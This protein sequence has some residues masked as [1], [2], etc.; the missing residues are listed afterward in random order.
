M[1]AAASRR[2]AP[3]PPLRRVRAPAEALVRTA[4]ERH[5]PRHR[6]PRLRGPGR[7][8]SE[9]ERM[10][11]PDA[12]G[13]L[14]LPGQIRLLRRRES[15]RTGRATCR[16]DG[17]RAPSASGSLRRR[18]PRCLAL[19]PRR[20]AGA[21]RALAANMETALNALWDSRRRPGRPHRGRRGRRGRAPGRAPGGAAAGSG[22]HDGRCRSVARRRSPQ[23]LGAPVRT[24]PDAPGDA[25]VVFH[26]SATRGRPCLRP[27][28]RRPRGARSSR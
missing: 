21:A 20:R 19:V 22:G 14:P 11:A 9:W 12:G 28:L 17:V 23:P 16:P 8:R 6:A 10:R 18:R 5:Q 26:A 13:R 2:A 27:R 1:S 24:P 3:A 7:R 15:S 25:D 4:L